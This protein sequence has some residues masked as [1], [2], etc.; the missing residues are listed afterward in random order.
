MINNLFA[1]CLLVEDFEKSRV[2]YRD[3]LGLKI[4]SQDGKYA[5]F[6]LRDTLLAIFQKDEAAAMFPKSHM[7][8]GGG[9]VLAFQT[10]DVDKACR[11]LKAKGIDIFEGPKKTPWGQ[12]VAYF[13]DP[14]SNIWEITT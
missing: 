8:A 7:T 4:N 2:F 14:D 11:E 5:D 10:D 6:K 3:V 13:K 12:T 1:V 9:C